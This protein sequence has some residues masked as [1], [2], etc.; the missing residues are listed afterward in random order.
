MNPRPEDEQTPSVTAARLQAEELRLRYLEIID[1][2]D[3]FPTA[4]NWQF[5]IDNA[6]TGLGPALY[7]K[8]LV[9]ADTDEDDLEPL[10]REA[11]HYFPLYLKA[12]P[13]DYAIYTVYSDTVTLPEET[14]KL[15]R[16]A[17]LF[18]ADSI[19]GLLRSGETGFALE[20]IDSYCAEYTEADLCAM[21]RLAA[22]L[23]SQPQLGCMEERRGLLGGASLKYICPNGH[24]NDGDVAFCSHSS[25]GLDIHGRTARQA[26]AIEAFRLRLRALENLFN[27]E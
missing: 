14:L 23:D 3:V 18:D 2:P 27:P 22:W 12:V 25:C 6:M 8:Y 26:S 16:E 4:T 10:Y 19:L 24:V 5:I 20:A 15:I 1:R 7:R 9:A 13:R 17:Q 21:R 11:L